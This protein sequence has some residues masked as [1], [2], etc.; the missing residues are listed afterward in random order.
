LNQKNKAKCCFN[1]LQKQLVAPFG[2]LP[3]KDIK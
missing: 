2:G 3:F 1:L